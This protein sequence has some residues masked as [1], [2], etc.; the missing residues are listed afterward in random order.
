MKSGI[1]FGDHC[2]GFAPIAG[3]RF[4]GLCG[5]GPDR[6][7]RRELPLDFGNPQM[8]E[9]IRDDPL[10]LVERMGVETCIGARGC[11]GP[12][13]SSQVKFPGFL[14]GVFGVGDVPLAD[15]EE[16]HV[17]QESAVGF[18]PS[19]KGRNHRAANFVFALG[20]GVDDANVG[21]VEHAQFF[22]QPVVD[23]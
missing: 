21:Q 22:E 19:E 7:S 6:G 9:K 1:E 8:I 3:D 12:Y 4:Q 14:V 23:K 10:E 2:D 5:M 16:A 20:D 13:Q 17:V 18:D 15:L 11:C